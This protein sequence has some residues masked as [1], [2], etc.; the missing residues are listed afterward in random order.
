VAIWAAR[1]SRGDHDLL[2]LGIRQSETMPHQ[3][4]GHYESCNRKGKKKREIASVP[5]LQNIFTIH[6][7]DA[8]KTTEH[9]NS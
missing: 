8:L 1:V 7:Q 3:I 9:M 4:H 6:D 2:L 5:K